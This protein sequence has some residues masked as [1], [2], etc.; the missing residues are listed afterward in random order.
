M[1]LR[2]ALLDCIRFRD[3][4]EL[5]LVLVLLDRLSRVT[6]SIMMMLYTKS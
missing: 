4:D 3:E 2:M 5:L 6:F 1:Q